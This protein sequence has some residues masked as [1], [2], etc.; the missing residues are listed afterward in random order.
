[1]GKIK[2]LIQKEFLQLRRDR[3][4][5]LILLSMPVLQ[6]L[7]LGYVVSAEI[8][9]IRVV[10]CD[11]DDTPLSRAIAHKLD[12]SPCFGRIFHVNTPGAV[13]ACLDRSEV[14]AGLVIPVHFSAHARTGRPAEIALLL[15]GQD[16]NT[17]TIALGYLNGLLAEFTSEQM[18]ANVKMLAQA[19]PPQALRANFLVRYNPNLQNSAFMIPGIIVFLLTL[20]T[21]G[22]SAAALVREREIGTME[23]LLV[24]P[25]KKYE[26]ILGKMIPF[27]AI[28]LAELFIGVTV[29]K[30]WYHIP[31][32]GNLALLTLFT[33]IYLFTSL[34]LGLLISASASTQQQALFMS[35]FVMLF[36][37]LM[38]G[39]MF[40]IENMPHWAQQLTYLNPMR[41]LMVVT[42][43]LLIKGS[44][45]RELY[46]Q[47]IALLLLG[48]FIFTIALLRFQKRS[49]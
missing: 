2:H 31:I 4:T 43:E 33:L 18:H 37:L 47:G 5:L 16:V 29:A 23:Q 32:A 12:A 21:S 19:P 39:F 6:L 35:W 41:Y 40:P 9:D 27:A 45:I 3:T 49:V 20:A 26:I 24:S 10:I 44:G 28:G 1:L 36:V 22:L 7:L 46:Q 38:S 34:G 42:R 14:E 25:L 13:Q 30:L 8:D 11:Q 17:A 48:G 15:D